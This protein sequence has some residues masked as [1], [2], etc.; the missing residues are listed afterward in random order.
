MPAT[1]ESIIRYGKYEQLKKYCYTNG[2]NKIYNEIRDHY[3]TLI[4]CICRQHN[5]L[6]IMVFLQRYSGYSFTETNDIL[7]AGIYTFW[8]SIN[9]LNYPIFELVYNN[10]HTR[11][12]MYSEKKRDLVSSVHMGYARI[13]SL[14]TD[15]DH[16]QKNA[17]QKTLQRMILMLDIESEDLLYI[18]INMNDLNTVKQYYYQHSFVLSQKFI[19]TQVLDNRISVD[20]E[21]CEWL[22]YI[23]YQ[24]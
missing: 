10:T 23:S 17:L 14:D 13:T 24:A 18:L 7:G 9:Q 21:I 4:E 1:L 11:Q 19:S 22:E 3:L 12:V 8:Y 16:Q 6:Q 20:Y 2:V 5:G 15:Y